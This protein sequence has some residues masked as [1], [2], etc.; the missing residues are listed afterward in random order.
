M[1]QAGF[2]ARGEA[3]TTRRRESTFVLGEELQQITLGEAIESCA[4]LQRPIVPL[5][6]RASSLEEGL[7]LKTMQSLAGA[8]TIHKNANQYRMQT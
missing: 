4:I 8:I 3:Q 1:I 6:R 5:E 7:H 2:P